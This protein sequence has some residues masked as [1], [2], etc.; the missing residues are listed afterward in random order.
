MADVK[1]LSVQTDQVR[2]IAERLRLAAIGEP[3]WRAEKEVFEYSEQSAK[4]VAVLKLMRAVQSLAA[5]E[6]LCERGL[7]ID[8]GSIVR[9]LNDAV[10]DVYFLLEEYPKTSGNVDKFTKAFFENTIDGYLEAETPTPT[11]DK[12]RNAQV[13]LVAGGHDDKLRKI[14]ERIYY[15]FCGYVHTNYAHTMEVYGGR[16][17]SFNLAGVPSSEER[18][19]RLPQIELAT[20]AVIHCAAF[21]AMRLD[22]KELF[23]EIRKLDQVR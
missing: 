10:E 17:P 23:D 22:L 13:R 18:A 4:V 11:R 20:T 9:C 12:V 1:R 16:T 3:I 7:F 14:S 5:L 15:A 6:A 2:I 19:R 8:L 21:I